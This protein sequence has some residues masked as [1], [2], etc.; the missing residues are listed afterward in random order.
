MTFVSKSN[1]IFF[2][3]YILYFAHRLQQTLPSS[4]SFREGRHVDVCKHCP[5]FMP[6]QIVKESPSLF[7]NQ[8]S[9]KPQLQGG[10]ASDQSWHE[11]EPF[12]IFLLCV[13]DWLCVL[14]CVLWEFRSFYARLH[15]LSSVL[16]VKQLWFCVV[17]VAH[18]CLAILSE[19]N[20]MNSFKVL[21]C[22]SRIKVEFYLLYATSQDL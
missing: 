2:L 17:A 5:L 15:A 20:R 6:W 22:W 11:T 18:I 9:S 8:C 7:P 13:S 12:A 10:S 3:L 16:H 4:W 19:V 1:T 14:G 21:I